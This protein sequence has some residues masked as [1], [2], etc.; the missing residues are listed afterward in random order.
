MKSRHPSLATHSEKTG[1][2]E[3]GRYDEI[4]LLAQRFKRTFPKRF[5]YEEIGGTPEGRPIFAFAASGDGRLT[6]QAARR[7]R[8]PVV[9][10][11]AGIHPGESEGKDAG[12]LL[13]ENL[14]RQS[15]TAGDLLKQ[16]TI[17][18][19]PVLNPDGHERF[20]A[21]NRPNQNG[22]VAMGW[23][24][25]ATNLNLNRDYTKAAAPEMQALLKS[26]NGWD[27][28]LFVD[29]HTSDGAEYQ[30]DVSIT[31]APENGG[32][33]RIAKA[34]AAM[35]AYVLGELKA[36]GH[37]PVDFYPDLKSPNDP[38]SGFA[39]WDFTP[40]FSH[41]YAGIR[42]RMATLVETHSW[43]DYPTRVR[44]T[45]NVLLASVR[46]AAA[47]GPELWSEAQKAD[48]EEKKLGGHDVTLTY[49]ASD[50]PNR[51]AFPGVAY[52]LSRSDISG[53]SKVTYD[54]AT[55]QIWNV[56]IYNRMAPKLVA[57]APL[58]GYLVP[59]AH[60]G[61]LAEKLKL[62]GI[63]FQVGTPA[64]QRR[65]E[66][67]RFD[68]ASFESQPLEGRTRVTVTGA[69]KPEDR[70]V[71]AGS[72]FVPTAQPK[73]RLVMH[74]LEPQAPDS[75]LSWGFFNEVFEQKEYM[76]DYVA[77]QVAETMLQGNPELRKEFE[78]R[79]RTD[80]AFAKDPHQRL[81]FFYRRHPSWDDRL[82]LYPIYRTDREP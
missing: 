11:Q 36:A 4:A 50:T 52:T 48:D 44:T 81:T 49:Q 75:F 47:H 74:L 33:P 66:T 22:P 8:R 24:T 39:L 60:A 6:P 28:I 70:A 35:Q 51:L 19:V 1:W 82:N 59:P 57:R 53:Q 58:G 21:Y 45:Y 23:R 71:P 17:V 67:F 43:K 61:W 68:S 32:S 18:F 41:A 16:V 55:P 80:P 62:H 42:N 30:P 76:E 5:R 78:H 73:A 46:Y 3:T 7:D 54:P 69:W 20:G 38:G 15:K 65:L 27:P 9:F 12:L 2:K 37:Q 64:V 10:I 29:T 13:L 31:V 77:E 56:P 25:T 40:R 79:L 34:T 14:L 72:L 63:S 26:L